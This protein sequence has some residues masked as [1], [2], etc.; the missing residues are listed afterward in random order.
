MNSVEPGKRV[1]ISDEFLER[2]MP[3]AATEVIG[4]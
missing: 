4:G 3:V 1:Y 2:C